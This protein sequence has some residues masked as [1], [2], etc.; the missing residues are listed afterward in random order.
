MRKVECPFYGVTPCGVP[1]PQIA[2]FIGIFDETLRKY[3]RREF[4]LGMIEANAKVAEALFRQATEEGNT[5]AAI[6]WTKARMGWR[7]RTGTEHSGS[8]SLSVSARIDVAVRKAAD[9][10]QG[11]GAE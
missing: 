10:I 3:Y 5:A 2:L 9:S 4:D 1:Q 8:L 6:W 7:E 11:N